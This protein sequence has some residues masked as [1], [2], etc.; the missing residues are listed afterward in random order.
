MTTN[1]SATADPFASV[2]ERDDRDRAADHAAAGDAKAVQPR[3]ESGRFAVKSEESPAPQVEFP[4]VEQQAQPNDTQEPARDRHVPLS[5]LLGEREK[6]KS[7]AKLREEAERRAAEHAAQLKVYERMLEQQ[8]MPQQP[9]QDVQQPPDFFQDP[10][11]AI[12]H[13]LASVQRQYE[14]RFLNY[15]ER[16]ARRVHGDAA[17]DQALMM[18]KQAGIAQQFVGAADPY[19]DLVAWHKRVQVMQEI[20]PDPAKYREKM[21]ADLRAKIMAELNAGGKAAATPQRFP[22][23]LASATQAGQQGSH[24]TDEAVANSIFDSNRNRRA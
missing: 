18:A 16:A 13:H 1:E 8:R 17:V 21:E 19:D 12:N 7:E 10:D 11:A 6:R 23:S 14:N 15:S 2:F 9:R 5:E 24:L 22:G 3:D 4:V 20:G